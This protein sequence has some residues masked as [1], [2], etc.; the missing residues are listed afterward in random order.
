[1]AR[2][3]GKSRVQTGCHGHGAGT[4]TESQKW[5]GTGRVWSIKV[6]YGAV[7]DIIVQSVQ[8]SVI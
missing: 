6:G 3:M 5:T 1:M 4:D 8:S 7:M 2:W